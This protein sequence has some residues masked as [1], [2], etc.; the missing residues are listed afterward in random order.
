M[1]EQTE[2]QGPKLEMSRDALV[3]MQIKAKGLTAPR[4]TVEDIDA[5]MGRVTCVG[6]VISGTTVTA[7]HAFLDEK[8]LLCSTHSACVSPENFDEEIGIYVA[9]DKLVPLVRE[10]LWELE[11]YRLYR[12]LNADPEP[13]A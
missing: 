4:I 6:S 9:R 8:F 3:E 10:K 12:E 5:L 2:D 1:S 13:E 7:M 11:G